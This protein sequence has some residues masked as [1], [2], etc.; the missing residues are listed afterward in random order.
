M[1]LRNMISG[2]G[3]DGSMIGLNDLSGIF[4]PL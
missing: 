4:Q 2:Q 1:A 3:S